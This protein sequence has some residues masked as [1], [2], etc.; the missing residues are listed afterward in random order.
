MDET[1]IIVF[2]ANIH[3]FNSSPT[4]QNRRN[5]Q[6]PYSQYLVHVQLPSLISAK[7]K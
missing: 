7:Y 6:V 2:Y 5:S 1:D 3:V 4:L